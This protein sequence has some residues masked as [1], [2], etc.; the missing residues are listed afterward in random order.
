MAD[1]AVA[2]GAA[3]RTT[4]LY[5]CVACR[6]LRPPGW[7][8]RFLSSPGTAGLGWP[9]KARRAR[10]ARWQLIHAAVD[11]AELALRLRLARRRAARAARRGRRHTLLLTDRSP[12]D[13]VVK[14]DPPAGGLTARWLRALAERYSA[15]ALLDAPGTVLSARDGE[16]G[17]AG[18]ERA[19]E[20]YRR[21]AAL[22]PGV[23]ILP[24]ETASSDEL[25][26]AVL[27]D[28]LAAGQRRAAS[29][30]A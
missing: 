24:T 14:H 20:S 12:L 18:L 17:P 5:G 19:R 21:W 25:A 30:S 2:R 11:T 16:H 3:V 4:Y 9:D 7:L 28:V 15:I 13:A 1:A 6:N 27:D 29:N 10:P 26:A 8:A 23:R 22:V